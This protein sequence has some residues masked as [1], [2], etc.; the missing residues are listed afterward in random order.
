MEIKRFKADTERD[1]T[2]ARQAKRNIYRHAEKPNMTG[3][4]LQNEP[5]GVT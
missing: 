5:Q 1:D 4:G 2:Y 3:T